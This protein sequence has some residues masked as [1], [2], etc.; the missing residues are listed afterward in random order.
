VDPANVKSLGKWTPEEDAKLTEEVKK[1]GKDWLAVATMVPG[2]SNL[3][4]RRRWINTVDPAKEKGKHRLGWKPEEDA[5][6]TEAVTKHGKH[7]ITIAALISGR[8]HKQCRERWVNCLDPD[9]GSNTAEEEHNAGNDEAPAS[10]P[11]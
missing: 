4:C 3:Q 10:V 8:T 11:I 1:H 5:K 6:L 9:R 2:R 7:W